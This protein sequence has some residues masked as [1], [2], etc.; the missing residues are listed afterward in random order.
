MTLKS[1]EDSK[2]ALVGM[3]FMTPFSERGKLKCVSLR[4][5]ASLSPAHV[6]ELVDAPV[7]GT[8]SF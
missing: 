5:T 8:G 2:I 1:R 7:L 4:E 6:A 3:V